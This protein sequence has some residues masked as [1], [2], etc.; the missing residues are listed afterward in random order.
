MGFPAV[1]FGLLAVRGAQVRIRGQE[2]NRPLLHQGLHRDRVVAQ[3]V[4]APEAALAGVGPWALPLGQDRAHRRRLVPPI[5]IDAPG[6][7][8]L[9]QLGGD[10]RQDL[11]HLQGGGDGYRTAVQKGQLLLLPL[12]RLQEAAVLDGDGRM[13]AQ[14]VQQAHLVAVVKAPREFCR[15]VIDG[16]QPVANDQGNAQF[17]AVTVQVVLRFRRQVGGGLQ[18]QQRL[19]GMLQVVRQRMAGRQD[20][21]AAHRAQRGKAAASRIEDHQGG[22]DNPQPYGEFLGQQKVEVRQGH[23]CRQTAPNLGHDSLHVDL[24]AVKGPVDEPLHTPT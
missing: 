6:L 7:Q 1:P 2:D 4:C 5:D 8:S 22:I 20:G 17:D 16:D 24:V 14:R 12:R 23:G 3:V 11:F 21:I 10:R 19:R 15:Q 9:A 13:R 18:A